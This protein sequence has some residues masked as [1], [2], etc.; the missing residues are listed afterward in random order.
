[1]S[2]HSTSRVVNMAWIHASFSIRGGKLSK[3]KFKN[4]GW[5]FI[6]IPFSSDSKCPY[7]GFKS[8]TG[9]R[10]QSN[11]FSATAEGDSKE[12]KHATI[13][14]NIASGVLLNFPGALTCCDQKVW[15]ETQTFSENYL[16]TP[17]LKSAQAIPGI[18]FTVQAQDSP[19][20][21]ELFQQS[22]GMTKG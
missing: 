17:L 14:K 3:E 13:Y 5:A 16:R 18:R 22:K 2:V 4:Q 7:F 12:T 15:N 8:P 11:S 19:E 6:L 10:S 20:S 9:S 21:A 1:M